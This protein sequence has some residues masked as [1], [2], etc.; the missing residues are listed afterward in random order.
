MPDH[1]LDRIY[2]SEDHYFPEGSSFCVKC[3]ASVSAARDPRCPCVPVKPMAM[4][5]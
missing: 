5:S 4:M 1:D 3:G 2:A